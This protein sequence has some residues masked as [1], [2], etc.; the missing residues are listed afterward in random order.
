[1]LS[2]QQTTSILHEANS[3]LDDHVL[4]ASNSA[5]RKA[6]K[7]AKEWS[8]DYPNHFV[9]IG[10]GMG[11][12]FVEVYSVHSSTRRIQVSC[13]KID[14]GD[15][16]FCDA[17]DNHLSA[18]TEMVAPLSAVRTVLSEMS[19]SYHMIVDFH[20]F[21]RGIRRSRQWFNKHTKR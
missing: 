13:G 8:K 14:R 10:E 15:V 12:L 7:V 20:C 21:Y 9:F 5:E 19:T 2:H 18:L 17:S 1:M 4:V 3:R 16:E 6:V 11:M